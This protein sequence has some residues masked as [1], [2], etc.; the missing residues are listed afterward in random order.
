MTVF[1]RLRQP[2]EAEETADGRA[3]RIDGY[4]EQTGPYPSAAVSDSPPCASCVF[5]GLLCGEGL[6]GTDEKAPAVY[7]T[8]K[9]TVLCAS[10]NVRGCCVVF[11]G[12]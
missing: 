12:Y 1:I 2:P 6:H 5:C 10:N 7:C 11:W 8:A 9:I 3:V 4:S